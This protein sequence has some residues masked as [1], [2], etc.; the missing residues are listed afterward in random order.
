MLTALPDVIHAV[1]KYEMKEESREIFFFR[2]GTV[3]F[4]NICHLESENILEFLKK[5]EENRYSD[6]IIQSESEIM[7]YSYADNG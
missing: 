6:N 2:E 4:W 1:A 7:T 5:Y 3:V